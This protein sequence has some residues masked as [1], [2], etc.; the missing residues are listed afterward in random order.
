MKIFK[1]VFESWKILFRLPSPLWIL[2]LST[3][4]NRV[5]MMAFPLLTVYLVRSL[6]LSPTDAGL[7]LSTCGV[8]SFLTSPV[9]GRMSDRWGAEKVL[10]VSLIFSGLTTIA[11]PFAQNFLVVLGLTALLAAGSELFR[12]AS[13]SLTA[14][15]A[16]PE[17]RKFAFTLLRI[18]SN[19]GFS[20][21]PALGGLFYKKVGFARIFYA[22]GITTLIAAVILICFLPTLKRPQRK[23]VPKISKYTLKERIK[24]V[25]VSNPD[26]TFFLL[27]VVSIIFVFFQFTSTISFYLVQSL[28]LPEYYFGLL[29]TLNATVVIFLEIPVNMAT[30]KLKNRT[31]LILGTVL[32][33]GGFGC[34]FLSRSG[35]GVAISGALLSLGE[36]VLF[37]ALSNY[38]AENAPHGKKGLFM[39]FYMMAFNLG[40]VLGPYFGFLTLE[41]YD[42]QGLSLLCF[43]LTLM[44]V[45][46][47]SRTSE[48]N[49]VKDT[50]IGEA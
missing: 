38:V 34:L 11:Y 8:V 30:L 9:A 45:L 17:D 29:F 3:F 14:E 42:H 5:G 23:P 22:D 26:F 43:G 6:G 32:L 24:L 48:R 19:L 10:K 41:N 1:A 20:A 4:V 31:T 21:G 15:L 50:E 39:G 27:G 36:I 13:L 46:F 47:F 35:L 49:F 25:T 2:A 40:F 33:G 18:A 16:S 44:S 28:K 12:P 7:V 37:P